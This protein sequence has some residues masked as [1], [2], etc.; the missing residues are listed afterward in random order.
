MR[1]NLNLPPT[2]EN[3]DIVSQAGN[4]LDQAVAWFKVNDIAKCLGYSRPR[5]AILDHV[6][7]EDKQQLQN[8]IGK[9]SKNKIKNI[10]TEQ[11]EIQIFKKFG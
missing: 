3:P 5:K 7:E 11:I 2:T 10:V 6:E 8:L 4:F 9:I 1:S